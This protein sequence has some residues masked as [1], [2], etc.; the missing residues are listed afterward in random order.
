MLKRLYLLSVCLVVSTSLFSQTKESAEGPGSSVWVGG[1]ITTFN[2]DWG[3][4]HASPFGCFT[5]QL[6]GITPFVDVNNLILHRVG[7]E[8]EARF[9]RWHDPAKGLTESS[10]L[11]GPKVSLVHYKDKL[12]FSGKFLVGE[13]HVD[14]PNPSPGTGNYFVYAPG[15]IAE[16]RVTRRLSARIDY[17]YQ[18]W[19]SFKGVPIP[20]VTSGSG[21]LTP[22]GFSAGASY[23]LFR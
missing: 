1:E 9:L 6:L 7:A 14:I 12:S 4:D 2:P 21:G 11:L 10:Y 16:Y 17:E 8:G 5:S 18:F 13:G 20:G 22:N 15:G 23:R 19:P 3:C